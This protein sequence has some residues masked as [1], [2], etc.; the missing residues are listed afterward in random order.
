VTE[1]ADILRRIVDRRREVVAAASGVGVDLPERHETL[2]V[3]ENPFLAAL[4]A[5][6]G[7][8]VIAE[9]K[10]GSPRIGS[11][12]GRVDP[13][14]QARMYAANGAAALSVVVE[15]DFFSGSY[16]LLARCREASGLPAIAKDFVV[17]PVQLVWAREA[18]ASAVLLIAALH[19]PG[20]LRRLARLARGLGLAPLVETHDAADIAR[21]DGAPWELV[22]INHRDLRTFEVDLDR[23]RDLV[24]LLPAGALRVA[25]SGIASAADVARL[26]A[27]GFDAFLVG[28]ALLLAGDPAAKLRELT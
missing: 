7:R 14:A 17:D 20:E 23:S 21:L 26:R 4:S 22:G 28:E 8:A 18:G 24:P 15:P 27:A 19:E 10:L 2:G 9:V 5:G 25:E 13:V 11:L 6:R 3:E 16:E 1:V 12:V